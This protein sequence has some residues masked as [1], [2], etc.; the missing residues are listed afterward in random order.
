MQKHSRAQTNTS[1]TPPR[2][3]LLHLQQRSHAKSNKG[4]ATGNGSVEAVRSK[5]CRRKLS[6]SEQL[7]LKTGRSEREQTR[8]NKKACGP[9]PL[10]GTPGQKASVASSTDPRASASPPRYLA[11]EPVRARSKSTAHGFVT[12]ATLQRRLRAPHP[13]Q[14]PQTP[15]CR[16][17][18]NVGTLHVLTPRVMSSIPWYRGSLMRASKRL[19][20]GFEKLF[21][22]R[23]L[24]D[25]DQFV[26]AMCV[27]SCQG[28]A[29]AR[30]VLSLYWTAPAEYV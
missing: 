21:R 10:I 25:R 12:G 17:C 22:S 2:G 13:V 16:L 24:R 27:A 15:P 4:A 14:H 20:P 9:G 23:R 18:D 19:A 5:I 30:S 29:P 26:S 11:S 1:T 7:V 28:R 8:T 3:Y 6:S